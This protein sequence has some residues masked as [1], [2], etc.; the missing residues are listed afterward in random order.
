MLS[1]LGSVL[2]DQLRTEITTQLVPKSVKL[3][4]ETRLISHYL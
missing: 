3:A 4:Q 1:I 2:I